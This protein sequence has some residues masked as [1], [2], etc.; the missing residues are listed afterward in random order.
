MS[1]FLKVLC[2]VGAELRAV[3]RQAHLT[4][5]LHAGARSHASQACKLLI[6]AV[7]VLGQCTRAREGRGRGGAGAELPES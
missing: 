5:L 3:P 6:E 4:W 2:L 1:N 7:S